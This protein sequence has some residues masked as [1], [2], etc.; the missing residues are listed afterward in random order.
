[1]SKTIIITVVESFNYPISGLQLLKMLLI[2]I[3]LLHFV[4]RSQYLQ[5][6]S[7]SMDYS[8]THVY[9]FNCDNLKIFVWIIF[10][11]NYELSKLRVRSNCLNYPFSILVTGS[12]GIQRKDRKT[13]KLL[14][15]INKV[16][17]R[18]P[19]TRCLTKVKRDRHVLEAKYSSY[20]QRD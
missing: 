11:Q 12:N 6:N 10:S 15:R 1:M 2:Y 8:H 9:T 20:S 4:I 17:P 18:H 3:C 16:L 13:V 14:N 5:N 19:A 7:W